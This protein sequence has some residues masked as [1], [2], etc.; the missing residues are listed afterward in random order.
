MSRTVSAVPASAPTHTPTEQF[1][2][3]LLRV[4]RAAP[5]TATDAQ[6]AFRTSVLVAALRCTLTYIVLPFVLPAVGLASGWGPAISITISLVAVVCIVSSMRRF[7]RAD[8][9][10]KWGYTALGAVVMVMLA[11]F[12]VIDIVDLAS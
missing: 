4:D 5:S 12:M 11:V 1:M 10:Y 2:R 9:R 7:W 8:H 3:R 6:N